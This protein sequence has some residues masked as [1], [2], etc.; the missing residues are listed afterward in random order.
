[1]VCTEGGGSMSEL[2]NSFLSVVCCESHATKN[3]SKRQCA[4]ISHATKCNKM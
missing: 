4:A 1:M 2:C 3:Y